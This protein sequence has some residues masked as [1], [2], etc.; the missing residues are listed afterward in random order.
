MLKPAQVLWVV[1]LVVWGLCCASPAHAQALRTDPGELPSLVLATDQNQP[2]KLERTRVSAKITGFVAEVEVSQSYSNPFSQPIEA[3]YVFPLPEN[4]AVNRLR[5]VIGERLIEGRVR[6]RREARARYDAAKRQGH[7]AALLEQERPNVFTQNVANIEPKKRIEVVVSYVQDLSYDAG[8]YEFVFP[9]VVGP[10]YNRGVSDADRLSPPYTAQERSG[11]TIALEVVTDAKTAV[12][13]YEA[14]NHELSAKTGSDGSLRLSL[15]EKDS[16]PNRD[17]VL[18]YRVAGAGPT[19]SLYLSEPK[20]GAGHFSL[21]VQPPALEVERLVGRRELVFVVDVS[22]SMSGAPLSACREVMRR[23]LGRL[24]P[25]DTFNVYTFAGSTRR[26]F[27]SPLEANSANVS[28]ALA[29]VSQLRAGGGTELRDAVA[30]ALLPD[31]DPSRHRYV[32]FLTDG[33]VGNEAAIFAAAQQ[34]NA[35]LASA[36][37]RARVFALGVGSSVNRHLIDGLSR[38]GDGLAQ[39]LSLA[40]PPERAVDQLFHRIDSPV[41]SD[42]KIDWGG[43]E[44][45]EIYPQPTPELFASH[46]VVLHGR[47]RGKLQRDVTLTAQNTQGRSAVGFRDSVK[48]TRPAPGS[49]SV[50]GTLWAREKVAQLERQLWSS[51]EQDPRGQIIALG[52]EHQ[53]VTPFTSFL[54]IDESRRVGDGKPKPIGEPLDQPAGVDVSTA[55]GRLRGHD[56]AQL[57]RTESPMEPPSSD[58]GANDAEQEAAESAPDDSDDGGEAVMT[59]ALSRVEHRRGCGCRIEGPPSHATDAAGGALAVGLLMGIW[60]VRR[61]SAASSRSARSRTGLF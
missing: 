6:E 61:R 50:L 57:A 32:F 45:S 33:Y 12:T 15:A 19:A 53:L 20:D 10:R 5:L 46:P 54:A 55:G 38:A 48:A 58:W 44:T 31:G 30:Q 26:A 36:G 41:L 43:L 42:L 34:F 40:D 37:R 27:P 21:V 4:A 22:G 56:S 14:P 52:L 13:R 51:P 11:R 49:S 2:L 7:T 9:M 25:Y 60:A 3:I 39:Y 1:C 8:E 29:M 18:R 59:G 16:I 35:K 24:R 28:A 47:Y 23:A 17:F